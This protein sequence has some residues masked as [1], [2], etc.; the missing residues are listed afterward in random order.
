M[1]VRGAGKMNPIEVRGR[2]EEVRRDFEGAVHDAR[3]ASV[4]HEELLAATRRAILNLDYF[5]SRRDAAQ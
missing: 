3:V 1:Q 4:A 2:V 5:R